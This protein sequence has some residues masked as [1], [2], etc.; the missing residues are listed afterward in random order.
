ML[1]RFTKV[2]LSGTSHL[3]LQVSLPTEWLSWNCGSERFVG[4]AHYGYR[5]V[6]VPLCWRPAYIEHGREMERR[7]RGCMKAQV[8]HLHLSRNCHN[9]DYRQMCDKPMYRR[10]RSHSQRT[11]KNTGKIAPCCPNDAG[12]DAKN[13]ANVAHLALCGPPH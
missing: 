3:R 4:R 1:V 5:R 6:H 11:G 8:G 7:W 9:S 10:C 2:F 12:N 13:A